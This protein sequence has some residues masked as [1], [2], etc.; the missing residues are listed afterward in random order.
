[1]NRIWRSGNVIDNDFFA[2]QSDLV[3]KY[4]ESERQARGLPG[5]YFLAVNRL[6]SEKNLLRLVEAFGKYKF[7]GGLWSL[8]I[9]GSGPQETALKSVIERNA[10]KDL[11]LISWKQ[12]LE[13]PAYYAL[14]SCFILASTS[15]PWGLVVNEAM[16]CGLPVLV[17]RY[18][19][20]VPELCR[21]GTN[22]YDFDPYNSEALAALMLK[23]SEGEYE[24]ENDECG[25]SEH[26][27]LF[28]PREL[29]FV[30][31]RLCRKLPLKPGIRIYH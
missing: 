17:S 19:G 20:C 30:A 14:A 29:G 10:I 16:A 24:S 18:C 1:M 6:S 27:S 11:V 8:V 9:V 7:S 4:P 5:K 31:R 3:K 22:G 25:I 23:F 26:H 28:Y 2:E 12:Y 15:E 21:R 13:L